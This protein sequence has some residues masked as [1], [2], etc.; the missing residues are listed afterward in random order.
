MVLL[1]LPA[2]LL[3]EIHRQASLLGGPLRRKGW[4]RV[5]EPCHE[6]AEH[7]WLDAGFLQLLGGGRA[8]PFRGRHRDRV[9]S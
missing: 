4:H 9:F 3:N 8:G 7:L 1:E 2:E 5:G 6:V